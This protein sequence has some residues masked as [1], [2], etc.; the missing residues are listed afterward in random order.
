M[1]HYFIKYAEYKSDHLQK[2][3]HWMKSCSKFLF[4]FFILDSRILSLSLFINH[5][6]NNVKNNNF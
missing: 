2:S 3:E 6:K 4:I 5:E 1:R